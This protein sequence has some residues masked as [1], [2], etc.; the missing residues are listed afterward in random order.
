RF[1]GARPV[2]TAV[3]LSHP[4]AQGA[5]LRR[6]AADPWQS[7]MPGGFEPRWPGRGN[8]LPAGQRRRAHARVVL[9]TSDQQLNRR[10]GRRTSGESRTRSR[11]MSVFSVAPS[12]VKDTLRLSILAVGVMVSGQGSAL[13]WGGTHPSTRRTISACSGP[14]PLT[15]A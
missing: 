4:P 5:Q 10:I 1:A 9:R 15:A 3:A 11:F 2:E 6:P 12:Y 8:R 7:P 13:A 14:S